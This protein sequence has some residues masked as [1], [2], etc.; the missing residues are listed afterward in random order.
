MCPQIDSQIRIVR[1]ARNA[2]R[3]FDGD[4]PV[5]CHRD[6]NLANCLVDEQDC[7]VDVIDFEMSAWDMRVADFSR[8]P[9][10]EWMLRLDLIDAFFDGHGRNLTAVEQEWLIVAHA[11]YSVSCLLW[12]ARAQLHRVRPR[13]ARLL[14]VSRKVVI[15]GYHA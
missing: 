8:Y 4:Q 13:S 10:W 3:V 11:Q 5:P 1:A 6:Y 9:Q 15:L 14:G 12:G 2:V 7:W